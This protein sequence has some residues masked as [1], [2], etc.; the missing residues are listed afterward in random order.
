MKKPLLAL[1]WLY[2]MCISPLL[3]SCCRFTP[4]CSAYAEEAIKSHS[5]FT[6]LWLILKRL[7]RC[8][9]WSKGGYDPV[10]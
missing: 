7:I 1:L 10:P 2:K 6:A 5:L 4:S 8:G 3:G 9:P